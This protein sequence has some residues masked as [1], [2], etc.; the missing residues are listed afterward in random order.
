M[1]CN[2][3]FAPIAYMH[4]Q[5]SVLR[6]V[7]GCSRRRNGARP[8]KGR[9]SRPRRDQRMARSSAKSGSKPGLPPQYM[10]AIEKFNQSA[11]GRRA[12]R[13]AE[14]DQSA[15]DRR[16]GH[17]TKQVRIYVERR[18]S[19]AGCRTWR[20]RLGRRCGRRCFGR[21]CLA[22][23]SAGRG[24]TGGSAARSGAPALTL[25]HLNGL[26]RRRRLGQGRLCAGADQRRSRSHCNPCFSHPESPVLKR[27]EASSGR[28]LYQIG[29]MLKT[30]HSRYFRIAGGRLCAAHSHFRKAG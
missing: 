17:C 16:S 21:G 27:D 22:C 24:A 7:V 8:I 3:A 4:P 19:R 6:T 5:R 25:G 9:L 14:T 2:S 26:A 1:P 20:Q 18:C 29:G 10:P 23:G 12:A 13:T 28:N 30:G 11:R 15:D